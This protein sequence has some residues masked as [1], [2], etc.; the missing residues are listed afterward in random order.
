MHIFKSRF[1]EK[2][3]TERWDEFTSPARFA[4][5]DDVMDLIYVSKRKDKKVRL[6]RRARSKREPF[7]CVFYG[8]IVA[9]EKGS[10]IKGVF[11][12]SIKDYVAVC[13]IVSLLIYIRGLVM[14]RGDSPVT[15]NVLLAAA[16][17]LGVFLLYNTRSAKRRFAEFI[18]RITD[19][20][21]DK[22][23]SK[24]EL[25]EKED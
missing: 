2:E 5:S 14:E 8:N 1:S 17:V 23:L 6:V 4:G 18:S 10:A 16:I 13:L 19:T 12:K 3:L 22:F 25:K 20:E 21:N 15:V 7:S 11:A 24:K 9:D